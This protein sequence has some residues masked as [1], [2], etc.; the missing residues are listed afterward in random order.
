M[1]YLPPVVI[2]VL[3]TSMAFVGATIS[4]DIDG[5]LYLP[6]IWRDISPQPNSTPGSGKTP[7]A[8]YTPSQNAILTPNATADSTL[9]LV[10]STPSVSSTPVS[11]TPGATQAATP[12]PTPTPTASV[13]SPYNV[14]AQDI[15]LQLEDMPPGFQLDKSE[16]LQISDEMAAWGCINGHVTWFSNEAERDSGPT[17]VQSISCVFENEADANLA[18]SNTIA[19]TE[20]ELGYTRIP[21]SS[22]GDESTALVATSTINGQEGETYYVFF[23][24]GNVWAALLVQGLAH[25]TEVEDAT[26][27]V[28]RILDKLPDSGN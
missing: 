7:M 23:Y 28:Q 18:Y 22:Y 16:P 25:V 11:A 20:H 9:T 13:P 3:V 8:T 4:Q 14:Q 15:V 10:T 19:H 26:P 5:D 27:Y 6:L 12:T 17:M 21:I 1:H 24:Q 2:F